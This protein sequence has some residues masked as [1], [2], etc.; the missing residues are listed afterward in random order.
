MGFDARLLS[1]I[2]VFAAAVEGGNFARAAAIVG[3]TPSGVSRAIGR[4]EARIGIRLFDRTPRAVDLTEEGRLFHLQVMPLLAGLEEAAA[5]A[6]G[7]AAAVSGRLRISSDPW[8]T[9]TVLAQHLPRF[10]SRYPNLRIDLATANTRDEMMTGFDIAIRFGSI[11]VGSQ[12]T[13]KLLDTRI[14]TC[15]SPAYLASRGEP[16]TPDEMAAHEAI[17]FRDPETGRAFDW[18]F[19][20][21]KEIVKAEVKGRVIF[22]DPS[23]AIAAC[24]AGQGIF[25]SLELGLE[26]WMSNG[27]LRSVLNE[28]SDERFSLN[29]F[30]T[31]RRLPPAKVRAFVEFLQEITAGDREKTRV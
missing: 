30:Y 22:D 8:F 9:R 10:L 23:A 1:G 27:A 11:G 26:P 20:K 17:L 31:S 4:L 3:L 15:A 16:G 28:W 29:V 21:G 6:A 5:A 24:V 14:V 25:Q 13:R 19:H 2:S 12:I 18:E 7:S